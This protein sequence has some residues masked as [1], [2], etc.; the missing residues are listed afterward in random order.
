MKMVLLKISLISAKEP[1]RFV[2]VSHLCWTNP[3]LKSVSVRGSEVK[4][5]VR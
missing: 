5:E 4:G 3:L 1:L 2:F